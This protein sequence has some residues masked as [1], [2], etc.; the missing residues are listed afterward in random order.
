MPRAHPR[1]SRPLAVGREHYAGD[2]AGTVTALTPGSA[3]DGSLGTH[4][5]GRPPVTRD[6]HYGLKMGLQAI[7]PAFVDGRPRLLRSL[8][9]ALVVPAQPAHRCGAGVQGLPEKW[10]DGAMQTTASFSSVMPG[11]PATTPERQAYSAYLDAHPNTP[12]KEEIQLATALA[13]S[14]SRPETVVLLSWP[15]TTATLTDLAVHAESTSSPPPG[16]KAPRQL[17]EQ[18][19]PSL[20]TP[21]GWQVPGGLGSVLGPLGPRR[22]VRRPMGA[23]QRGPLCVADPQ[24]RRVRDC[25]AE[26]Y[27]ARLDP[28]TAWKIFVAWSRAGEWAKATRWGRIGLDKHKGH[29]RWRS[30]KDDLAWAALLAGEY[31]DAAERWGQLLKRG[32]R[33]G[34]KSRFYHALSLYRAGRFQEAADA[35]SPLTQRRTSALQP[36]TGARRPAAGL[37]TD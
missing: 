20:V 36:T 2:L 10:P 3:H 1:L 14:K 31:E 25:L 17:D 12:R 33:F 11:L 13:Y 7:L 18:D 16:T 27:E 5:N 8:V 28:E 24:L 21:A 23:G 30:A 32:G 19:A 37:P 29:W 9:Q 15:S 6:G 22:A 35:L 4:P 26:D 34:R